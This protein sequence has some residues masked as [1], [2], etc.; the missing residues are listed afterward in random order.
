MEL[1]MNSEKYY[2]NSA[3]ILQKKEYKLMIGKKKKKTMNSTY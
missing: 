1:W 3:K 2:M